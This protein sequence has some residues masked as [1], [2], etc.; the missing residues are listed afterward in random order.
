[1][2]PGVEGIRFI[3]MNWDNRK[4]Q[5]ESSTLAFKDYYIVRNTL[6]SQTVQRVVTEPDILFS[7]RTLGGMNGIPNIL[8]RTGSSRWIN[9]A[10]LN[11]KAGSEGP[12]IIK[13][14]IKISFN[15]I[16]RNVEAESAPTD[17]V[18]LPG[19]WPFT[20]GRFGGSTNPPIAFPMQNAERP[21][22]VAVKLLN[23]GRIR[24][25][26]RAPRGVGLAVL[27][28]LNLRDWEY[29]GEVGNPTGILDFV[30][31]DPI[32]FEERRFYRVTV[33]P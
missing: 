21:E 8:E 15:A 19:Q 30:D 26:L 6:Q 22:I 11:G 29:A 3:R 7:V 18:I 32:F 27:R 1:M 28:S 5:F 25:T 13:P 9:N 12:G 31:D 4:R 2:R 16:G 17:S 33:A 14:P 10:D 24:L 20:W 23:D